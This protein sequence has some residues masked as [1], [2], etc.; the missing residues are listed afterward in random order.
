MTRPLP[1]T[2]ASVRRAILAARKAGLRVTG[3][4]PDG[5]VM[6][7]DGDK[8]PDPVVER[9]PPLQTASPTSKWEDAEA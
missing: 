4:R 1:F 8:A 7:S 3:I 5:T 6:V 2:E 9:S